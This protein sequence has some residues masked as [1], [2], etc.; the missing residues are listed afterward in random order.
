MVFGGGAF[1]AVAA[2]WFCGVFPVS[3]GVAGF[4]SFGFHFLVVLCVRCFFEL[5][6]GFFVAGGAGV[7]G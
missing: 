2:S 5:F 6:L 3:G 4:A 1:V 7:G